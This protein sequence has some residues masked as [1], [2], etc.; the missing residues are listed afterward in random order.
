MMRRLLRK[1][2]GSVAIEFTLVLPILLFLFIG[3]YDI[4]FLM[5]D[6]MQVEQAASAGASYAVKKGA[7]AFSASNITTVVTNATWP[8]T[9]SA[10]PTA[11]KVCGCPNSDGSGFTSATCGNTCSNG[12]AAGTY[13]VIAAQATATPIFNWPGYPTTLKSQV[14]VRLG[15]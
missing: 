6:Q 7:A 13:A 11:F 3:T 2:D 15:P 8:K 4:G 14:T 5:F 12:F 1:T 10:T 9:I